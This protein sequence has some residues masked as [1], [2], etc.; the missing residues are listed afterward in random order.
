MHIHLG[1]FFFLTFSEVFSV[2][3]SLIGGLLTAFLGLIIAR[4]S[5]Q[6]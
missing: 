4:Q 1:R 6:Y 3:R 2:F 5:L